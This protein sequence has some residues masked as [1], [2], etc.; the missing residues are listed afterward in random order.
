MCTADPLNADAR[1]LLGVI[2]RQM[3]KFLPA[4]ELVTEAISLK[5]RQVRFQRELKLIRSLE[6]NAYGRR[7][8]TYPGNTNTPVGQDAA[9]PAYM[10]GGLAAWMPMT[11]ET[12]P[13]AMTAHA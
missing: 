9:V 5:P 2:A 12:C 1:F 6:S 3:R 13:A 8:V 7:R 10:P 4:A 11:P